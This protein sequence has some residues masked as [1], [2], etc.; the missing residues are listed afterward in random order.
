[1]KQDEIQIGKSP[2]QSLEEASHDCN[3]GSKPGVSQSLDSPRR[4][5][6]LPTFQIH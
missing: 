1:M 6:D 4:A 5:G 2:N 3:E